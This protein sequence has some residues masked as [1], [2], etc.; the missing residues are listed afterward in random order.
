MVAA[1][2]RQ[3]LLPLQELCFMLDSQSPDAYERAV[4]NKS[5]AAVHDHFWAHGRQGKGSPIAASSGACSTHKLFLPHQTS[6]SPNPPPSPPLD[7]PSSPFAAS[8]PE[9][10]IL[11]TTAARA[12]SAGRRDGF[13]DVT[14][15]TTALQLQGC[16]GSCFASSKHQAHVHVAAADDS[17]EAA[18]LPWTIHHNIKL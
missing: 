7:S 16:L 18:S 15:Q 6:Q 5:A 9:P 14:H 12:W 1:A 10:Q 2:I 4:L 13:A 8:A 11:R 17:L 3:G